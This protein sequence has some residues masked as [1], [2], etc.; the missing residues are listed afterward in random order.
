MA[1]DFLLHEHLQECCPDVHS[2]RLQAL[3][4]VA[5]GLTRSREL[6]ISS[7]GKYLAGDSKIKHRIKKVDRLISNKHLYTELADIY[8]GLS[9][10]VFKYLEQ[11]NYVPL[12]VDLCYLKDTHDVQMLSA[13]V[14]IQGR[15]LPIY[16]DV[17]DINNLK[18]RAPEFISN[19]IKCIPKNRDVLFIMDAGFGEDWFEAIEANNFYWLV[20][21]RGGKH[22]KLSV[23]DEWKDARELFERAPARAKCYNN[24]FI[25]KRHSR[26][27]RVIIKKANAKSLTKKPEKL[28]RNYN[29]ANGNYQ[30]LAVEPWILAT[31]LPESYDTT[32]II[33]AYKK[34]MQIEESFR[35]VK[36][37]RFGLGGRYIQTRCAY[38]WG[39]SMLL[40]AIAQITLWVIGVIGHARGLQSEFSSNTQK[41][42]KVFSYFFMG[43]LIVELGMIDKL[44]IDY[45]TLPDLVANELARVW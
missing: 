14:A 36:S 11:D 22:I 26:P 7:I 12:V 42:K 20:R 5:S 29:S 16:R 23:D 35:D 41:N 44:N 2:T 31:N 1:I 4:D 43:K 30:R 18:G 21:A 39:V 24:A 3:M 15:T 45:E 9:S 8:S 10:Y 38:K 28:P 32:K 19:L 34:R 33:N 27:C 13:E 40:A 25:T 17:F 6:S 37:H